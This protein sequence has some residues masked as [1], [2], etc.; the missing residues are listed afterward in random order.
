MPRKQAK[1]FSFENINCQIK[2]DAAFQSRL[3]RLLAPSVQC[4][5][6]GML[7]AG[8]FKPRGIEYIWLA[9]ARNATGGR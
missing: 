2:T 6:P 7:F 3:N 5:S 1:A 9:A 8:H 4:L